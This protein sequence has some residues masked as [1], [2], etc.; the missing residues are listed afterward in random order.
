MPF[1]LCQIQAPSTLLISDILSEICL[2]FLSVLL[3]LHADV[4]FCL[5]GFIEVT[6]N[7]R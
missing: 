5:F 7:N 4:F 2:Y 6:V 1:G 3:L